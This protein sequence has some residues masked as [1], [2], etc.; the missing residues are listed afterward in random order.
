MNMMSKWKFGDRG[1]LSENRIFD[2]VF[3]LYA[4]V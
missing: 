3:Q 2:W 1:H 4:S